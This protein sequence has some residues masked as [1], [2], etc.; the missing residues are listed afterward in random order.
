MVMIHAVLGMKYDCAGEDQPTD[1]LLSFCGIIRGDGYEQ[2]TWKNFN[3]IEL[4]VLIWVALKIAVFSKVRPCSVVEVYQH[5]SGTYCLHL[6]GQKANQV[7]SSC[8]LTF[9]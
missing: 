2:W 6:Q 9:F 4:E 8:C 7:A 1:I 3:V 5:F